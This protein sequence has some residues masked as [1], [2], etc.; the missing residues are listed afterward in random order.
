[1]ILKEIGNNIKSK[2]ALELLQ[3]MRPTLTK[4][5]KEDLIRV[6]VLPI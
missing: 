6:N 3:I 1:M 5:I 2:E 4:Y